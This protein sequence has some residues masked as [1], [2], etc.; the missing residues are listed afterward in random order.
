MSLVKL[1]WSSHYS[2]SIRMSEYT[3][4]TMKFRLPVK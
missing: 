3:N 4:D 1:K 2:L